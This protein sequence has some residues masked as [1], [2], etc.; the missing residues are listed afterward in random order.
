MFSNA[1]AEDQIN[2]SITCK[3]LS[4][5]ITVVNDGEVNF[6]GSINDEYSTGDTLI[7]SYTFSDHLKVL[8]TDPF[9]KKVPLGFV[10][11]KFCTDS[12]N[13][14]YYKFLVTHAG[15]LMYEDPISY[16]EFSPR[17]LRIRKSGGSTKQINLSK[18]QE[19]KFSGYY[20]YEDIGHF[21]RVNALD[22]RG[23]NEEIKNIIQKMDSPK[24]K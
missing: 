10:S 1:Q 20:F 17:H 15:T 16:L 23:D 2:G 22:C 7:L 3:V 8:L 21:V 18:Y 12:Y 14:R 6:Y 24:V 13:C 11:D 5:R 19:G 4:D 9:N